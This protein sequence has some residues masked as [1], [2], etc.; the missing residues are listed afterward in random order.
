MQVIKN[1]DAYQ[2]GFEDG[3]EFYNRSMDCKISRAIG[4]SL[5]VSVCASPDAYFNDNVTTL[6]AE[7]WCWSNSNFSYI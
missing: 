6:D 4:N 2:S 3:G 7:E 5:K 1:L